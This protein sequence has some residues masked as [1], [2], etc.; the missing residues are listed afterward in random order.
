M[1]ASESTVSVV[2]P[3]Y[4]YGRFVTDAVQTALAQTHC[5][6][7]IIV[8]DDGSTDDTRG[9][10]APYMD[11][12]R[13]VHQEN[14]GLS[15]ARNT[16]IRHARGE[17]IALLDADDLWHPRKTEIQ[18]AAVGADD[19]IGLVGSPEYV[20]DMP[21]VLPEPPRIRRFGARD[22]LTRPPVAPSTVLVRRSCFDTVGY[23]DESLT[24]V[25][26]RDM[27]LRLAVSFGALQVTSPCWHYRMHP[28]Q[29]NRNSQRMLDNYDRVLQRF[30]SEHPQFIQ[31][32]R[33]AMAYMHMDAA[34]SFSGQGDRRA[35]I[36]HVLRSGLYW[37]F[38]LGN[39]AQRNRLLRL[40]L[41]A[42]FILGRS[43]KS[44]L[45]G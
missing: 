14:R 18:L 36:M 31:L 40:R 43:P 10:L 1:R 2:I 33:F 44:L 12:I 45:W 24:S 11:R 17:W 22:C 27:W 23:F 7:E 8:V 42:R 38:S 4:N 39:H 25:E 16:G 41:L 29:M 21:E 34:R 15:A 37:P 5:P 30:F 35:A 6:L 20:G 3:S 19:T 26:D 13:Y 9:R 32:R 28:E